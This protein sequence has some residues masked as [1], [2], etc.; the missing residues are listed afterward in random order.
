MYMFKEFKFFHKE[1][2]FKKLI[3]LK[4]IIT[5]AEEAAKHGTPYLGIK[6]LYGPYKFEIPNV[7]SQRINV[8][9][10]AQKKQGSKATN[11]NV[12][13]YTYAIVSVLD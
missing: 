7:V 4:K 9:L 10:G 13:K 2:H 1:Q 12:L 5:E 8:L 6:N 3:L 11:F